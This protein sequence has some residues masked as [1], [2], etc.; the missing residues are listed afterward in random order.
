[1]V[2]AAQA[3]AADGV[4]GPLP[5]T[6]EHELAGLLVE[7]LPW[8]D[9]LR[10]LKSG[11]EALSAAVR[12]ARA[13]TGRDRV[14]TCGYHGWH[15][16]C[17]SGPGVPQV[18]QSLSSSIGFNDVAAGRSAIREQN[19]AAV[20]VE[21]VIDAPPDP[22]W[23]G[24]LREEC[25]AAGTVL[26]FDEIK[27][28]LRLAIGGAAER[29]GVSPDLVVLGKGLANGFPLAVVGG[30]RTVMEA[31]EHTW[32]SSTLATEQVSLRAAIAAVRVTQREDVPGHLGRVGAQLYAGL[33]RLCQKYRSVGAAVHGMP[34]MCYLGFATDDRGWQL[35]SAMAARGIIW[36]P[37]AYNFV[38][39]A[40]TE[41][42]IDRTL[43]MLDE[44]LHEIP[45]G[46]SG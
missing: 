17:Q 16:W 7:L 31:L 44:A 45:S 26:I 14:I 24:M 12:I 19:A 33:E 42:D 25:D 1:V 37:T 35:T 13:S 28:A 6:A 21:P 22:T 34:E 5:P 38:S 43:L 23:L 9:Q 10:F 15:D 46:E 30:R 4:V 39:L 27:T 36:K 32:I 11:A 2:E 40:H 8:V 3:A 18:V 20:V 41:A 29:Y